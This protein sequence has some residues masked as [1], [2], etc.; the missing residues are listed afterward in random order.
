[1][2]VAVVKEEAPGERRVALAPS[3]V[4]RLTQRA[5]ITVE[6]GA[7]AKA[8]YLDEAY[9]DPGAGIADRPA[10]ISIAGVALSLRAP[11][12]SLELGP[13]GPPW[14]RWAA[15]MGTSLGPCRHEG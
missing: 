2:K 10:I 14:S 13:P 15:A 6:R 5:S 11:S 12:E 4:R 3:D 1:M 8:G 7:G 9:V